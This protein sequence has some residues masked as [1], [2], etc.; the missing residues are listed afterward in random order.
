MPTTNYTIRLDSALLVEFKSKC[1]QCN[2][3]P[4]AVLKNFI[5]E[6]IDVMQNPQESNA[7][8][9]AKSNANCIT[10][11]NADDVMQYQQPL[12]DRNAVQ[13]MIDNALLA[14][15]DYADIHETVAE[16]VNAQIERFSDSVDDHTQMIVDGSHAI[17]K[18][19][20]SL[21]HIDDRIDSMSDSWM[22]LTQQVEEVKG[23]LGWTEDED[24]MVS[25]DGLVYHK[26]IQSLL[27][28]S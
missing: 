8:C 7:D 4:S 19:R 24:G 25:I 22:N 12:L 3:A 14:K 17:G 16:A 13:E 20:Q 27:K 9:N 6:Y 28:G 21:K 18:M 5:T 23:V 26:Q 2:A 11:R 15:V 10:N 1:E